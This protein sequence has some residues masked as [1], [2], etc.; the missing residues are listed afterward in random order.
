M[1]LIFT[2]GFTGV[3]LSDSNDADCVL[4]AEE[5]FLLFVE[6]IKVLSTRYKSTRQLLAKLFKMQLATLL[7]DCFFCSLP[8]N[9]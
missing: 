4:E 1:E 8:V 9:G 7:L 5:Y 3:K 2:L 6:V